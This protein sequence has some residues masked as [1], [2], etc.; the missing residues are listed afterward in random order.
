[1]KTKEKAL[2]LLCCLVYFTSYI[3]RINYGAVIP[4][5]IADLGIT[6]GQAGLAV[7]GC[8]IT[9]GLGQPVTGWLGDRV[10][11][12]YII[13]AG[14]LGTALCNITA[15][16]QNSVAVIAAIWCCNGFFQ[17]MMWPPLLRI[18]AETMPGERYRRTCVNVTTSANIGTI[19]VYLTAPLLISLG[20]WRLVLALPAAAA[21]AVA[22]SWQGLVTA[23]REAK[24]R[25]KPAADGHTEAPVSTWRLLLLSGM[26]LILGGIALQGLLRDGI[27]TWMPTYISEAF[28][29]EAGVSILTAAVLPIFAVICIRLS[30]RVYCWCGYNELVTSI[31]FFGISAVGALLL[32]LF[33]DNVLLSVL[34]MAL[35]CGSCHVVN[36]MLISYTP[37]RYEAYGRV[38]TMSGI[39]NAFTYL[40][41]ALSA[42]GFAA[43]ADRWGWRPLVLVWLAGALA[44][45]LL[46]LAN[47]RRWKSFIGR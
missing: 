10:P 42:Y 21:L 45:G 39:V 28:H 38:S 36:Q 2:P 8:F 44:G 14:L 11:P 6:K 46:C 34:L 37:V 24:A 3:T 18:I 16:L 13:T 9:Y 17:S 41:S 25:P 30:D 20:S 23:G 26:P 35:I 27:T 5:V 12:K 33:F 15:S 7:T 4:A 40:G 32:F 22:L 47:L 43:I 1:M 29:L 31:L 19:V